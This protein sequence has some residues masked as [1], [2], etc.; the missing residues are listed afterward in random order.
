[1][2]HIIITLT[3]C[4]VL[5]IITPIVLAGTVHWGYAST[6]QEAADIANKAANER[7]KSKKTCVTTKAIVGTETCRVGGPKGWECYAVS[8]NHKGS[9]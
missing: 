2:R 8:A 4:M 6:A 5:L 9:C 7:A 1:M 3:I